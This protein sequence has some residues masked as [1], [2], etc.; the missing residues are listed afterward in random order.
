MEDY[1]KALEDAESCVELN[2]SWAKGYQRKGLAQ[3]YLN[4]LEEAKKTYQIGL[5]IDP[6]NVQLQEG[7]YKFEII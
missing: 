2:P 5:A 3:F 1:S 7:I 6:N 4:D